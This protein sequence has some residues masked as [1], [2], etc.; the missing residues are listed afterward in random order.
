MKSYKNIK[1]S[2]SRIVPDIKAEVIMADLI[3]KGLEPENIVVVNQGTFSRNYSRDI[4]RIH[5]DTARNLLMIHISRDSLYDVLPEGLFH[6]VSR[7][8]NKDAD[9]RKIEFKKQKQEEINA[10]MFFLPFDH[11][12][13]FQSIRLELQLFDIF[14]DP[15]SEFKQLFKFERSFPEHYIR[16]FLGFLPFSDDIKGDI[17]LTAFCLSE[18]LQ[19][20]VEYSSCYRTVELKMDSMDHDQQAGNILGEDLVCGDHYEEEI[21]SWKFSIHCF[22]D[23]D[24]ATYADLKTGFVKNMISRFYDIFLPVEVEAETEFICHTNREFILGESDAATQ[25]GD[26]IYL[27][28]NIFL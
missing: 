5:P 18:L 24:V 3:D 7:F 17:E 6:E 8:N 19:K 12:M 2:I 14:R 22:D 20:E 4:T 23:G 26:G 21:L 11:E 1:E 27:G 28:Y 16:R 9:E 15:L 10:R 13:F 25:Q